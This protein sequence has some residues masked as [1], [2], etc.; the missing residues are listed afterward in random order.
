MLETLNMVL[1]TLS[2]FVFIGLVLHLVN[3]YDL[4]L[5]GI[6]AIPM[7]VI[8]TINFIIL[9]VT[10]TVTV[11]PYIVT[12]VI[13]LCWDFAIGISV[14]KFKNMKLTISYVIMFALILIG[15]IL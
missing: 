2:C 15:G 6:V 7:Y 14:F 8:L 10:N 12:V 11:I 9:W 5:L 13:I 1:L 3:K 4:I